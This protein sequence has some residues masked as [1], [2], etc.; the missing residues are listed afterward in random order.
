MEFGGIEELIGGLIG[1]IKGPEWRRHGSG[2]T[3]YLEP[4]FKGKGWERAMVKSYLSD[5]IDSLRLELRRT[6]DIGIVEISFFAPAS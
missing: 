5:I 6:M 1:L 4:S 3:T 2:T